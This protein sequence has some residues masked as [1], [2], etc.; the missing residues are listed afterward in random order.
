MQLADAI[1]SG[2]DPDALLRQLCASPL[3][4]NATGREVGAAVLRSAGTDSGG[5]GPAHRAAAV[6]DEQ[7]VASL[8][9]HLGA[10]PLA[11]DATGR[12]PAEL[13]PPPSQ[14][15]PS[16]LGELTPLAEVLGPLQLGDECT[17]IL[18]NAGYMHVGDVRAI[19][20][21][22]LIEIGLRKPHAQRIITACGAA[23]AE[24]SAAPSSHSHRT[25]QHPPLRGY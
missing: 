20:L 17:E 9:V 5:R 10:D 18:H 2:A 21:A 11:T 14:R 4:R 19:V 23:K 3:L 25:A 12:R 1:A 6:G 15:R 8:V 16:Q 24:F 22:D 7:L 13:L